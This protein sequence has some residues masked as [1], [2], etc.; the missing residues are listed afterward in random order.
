MMAKAK[1]A[2]F[3]MVRLGH[4]QTPQDNEQCFGEKA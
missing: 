3:L 4:R 2:H 1:S